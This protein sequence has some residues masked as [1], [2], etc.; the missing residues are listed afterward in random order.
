[1]LTLPHKE[2]KSLPRLLGTEAGVP[3]LGSARGVLPIGPNS[4]PGLRDQWNSSSLFV[5]S[6]ARK[7]ILSY[8]YTMQQQGLMNNVTCA[9]ADTSPITF[10]DS[11]PSNQLRYRGVCVNG[12]T[13]VFDS[14]SEV[15]ESTQN[16]LAFMACKS[17]TPQSS[18]AEGP[19]Y[20]IYLRGGRG[21]GYSSFVGNISCT[22]SPMR[23][24]YFAITYGTREAYFTT[25]VANP[26]DKPAVSANLST[27]PAFLQSSTHIVGELVSWAQRWNSNMVAES[28]S[29]VGVKLFNIS[30]AERDEEYLK[31]Y[32][33]TIQG[34][35]D[36]SVS[37]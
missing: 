1:M 27:H 4:I 32:A 11:A 26:V 14:E 17:V 37:L 20:F 13:S 19:I 5:N 9:Y 16:G 28:V 3:F 36:Y 33:A 22:V 31:L 8:S 10:N 24:D 7:G 29:T 34:V 23:A 25:H 2:Y 35:L 21:P 18:E 30:Q 15:E 6:T 12:Q